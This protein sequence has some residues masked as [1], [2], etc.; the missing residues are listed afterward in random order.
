MTDGVAFYWLSRKQVTFCWKLV[1]LL[2]AK[3]KQNCFLVDAYEPSGGTNC[4]VESLV[5]SPRVSL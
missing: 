5:V 3:K 1:H 4:S 2:D